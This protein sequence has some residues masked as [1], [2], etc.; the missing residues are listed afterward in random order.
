MKILIE[1]HHGF[2]M[3]NHIASVDFKTAF[4]RVNRKELLRIPASDQVPQQ[5]I[6]YTH[7]HTQ[8]I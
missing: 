5:T 1:K 2:N 7:A 6:Q 4:D 8:F 3:E